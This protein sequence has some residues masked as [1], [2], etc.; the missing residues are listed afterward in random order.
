MVFS[1]IGE[2]ITLAGECGTPGNDDGD[3]LKA[4]FSTA[5][6][7]IACLDNCIILVTDTSNREVREIL[8]DGPCPAIQGKFPQS[9][10]PTHSWVNLKV[11]V[12]LEV[13]LLH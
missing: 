4:R 8:P 6:E 9:V 3:A 7:D 1:S 5:V 11:S 12:T 10:Q 13:E 2:V